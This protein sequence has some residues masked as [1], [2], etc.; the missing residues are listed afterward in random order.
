MPDVAAVRMRSRVGE[1]EALL[2]SAGLGAFAVLEWEV[3]ADG[4][5][6]AGNGR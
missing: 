4:S 3:A 6:S 2:D 5:S 1:A